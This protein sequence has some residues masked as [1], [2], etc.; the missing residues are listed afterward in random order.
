MKLFDSKGRLVAENLHM[1]KNYFERMRGLLGTRTL[2]EGH[3][4]MIPHCQGIHTV[5]MQ[6]AIDALFLN[7]N[8]KVVSVAAAIPPNRLGPVHLDAHS[9]I[10]LPAGTAEKFGI[11][12]GQA[13]GFE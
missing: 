13:L 1:A 12:P 8:G 10:E 4:L 2:E 9:V 7:K 11:E 5:G 3:A 6:Y